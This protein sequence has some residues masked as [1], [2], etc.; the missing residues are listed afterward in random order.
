MHVPLLDLQAQYAAIRSEVR[1]AIDSVLESQRFILGPHVSQCETELARY[2]QVAH[3]IGVASGSDALLLA[4]MAIGIAAGDE[5]ITTPH[6][7]FATA[8]AVARLGGVPVFVD[9]DPHTC[10]VAVEQVEARVTSHTKAILPVHLY[11]QC[12]DMGPLLALA[13]RHGLMVVEDAAQAIGAE[14][15]LPLARNPGDDLMATRRPAGSMGQLGCLS[16]Y[17]S[18]A[19]GGYGDGGMVLTDDPAL[20]ERVRTLRV[21]GGLK[22]YYHDMVGVNSRLDELQA[23]VLGVK[24]RYVDRWISARQANAARYQRLFQD[25][26]LT[27]APG[28]LDLEKPVALPSIAP[29]RT[30]IFYVYAIR[31]R[32]RDRLRAYLA[33]HGV[34]TEVYYPLPLHLQ[35]CFA[36]LGYRPGDF[37][38][39]ERAAQESL[40][41]PMYPE[42]SE[43]QQTYVVEQIATFYRQREFPLA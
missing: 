6:T 22:K 5:V 17:P 18:K 10:N 25:A 14:C 19:L 40:A 28:K 41:L 43:S 7:F 8:G 15:L 35:P 21:H 3:A 31:A 38:E 13:R 2:C 11:G 12:A 42:L 29:G 30:H 37:P 24:L 9:I 36:T 16:F 23:A 33:E 4:L 39:A 1:A 34:G 26:G 32:E 27:G 20:A